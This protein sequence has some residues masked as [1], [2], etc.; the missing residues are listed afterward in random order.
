MWFAR[1]PEEP[2]EDCV[3][4]GARYNSRLSGFPGGSLDAR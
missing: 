4:L 1:T 3:E 2:F